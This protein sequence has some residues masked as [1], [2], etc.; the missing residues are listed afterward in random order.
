MKYLRLAK[1]E[2]E[3]VE[4]EEEEEEDRDDDKT[5]IPRESIMID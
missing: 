2:R 5:N 1:Q 4:E 3:E